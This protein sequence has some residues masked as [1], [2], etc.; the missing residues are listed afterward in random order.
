MQSYSMYHHNNYYLRAK[1]LFQ[2]KKAFAVSM[3]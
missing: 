3:L 2:V 1:G